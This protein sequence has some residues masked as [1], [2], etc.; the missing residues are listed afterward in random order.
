MFP[1]LH[2]NYKE[3]FH[4]AKGRLS[5]ALA[6]IP[7]EYWYLKPVQNPKIELLGEDKFRSAHIRDALAQGASGKDMGHVTEQADTQIATAFRWQDSKIIVKKAPSYLMKQVIDSGMSTSDFYLQILGHEWGH[8][9]PPYLRDQDKTV[10]SRAMCLSEE[11]FDITLEQFGFDPNKYVYDIYGRVVEI[12]EPNTRKFVESIGQTRDKRIE[13]IVPD[14]YSNYILYLDWCRRNGRNPF[15]D[16]EPNRLLAEYQNSSDFVSTINSNEIINLAVVDAALSFGGFEN[17]L[18]LFVSTQYID[19]GGIE[20]SDLTA[21]LQEPN[22]PQRRALE[23]ITRADQAKALLEE[24]APSFLYMLAHFTDFQ[25]LAELVER[26]MLDQSLTQV[27][28][29][30]EALVGASKKGRHEQAIGDTSYEPMALGVM[31]EAYNEAFERPH[32][33]VGKDIPK[34]LR[35]IGKFRVEHI[36]K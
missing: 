34:L 26:N 31:R 30:K 18:R 28:R 5:E 20:T 1:E 27:H 32:E 14:I 3:V 22:S 16:D 8:L 6:M 2:I 9:L 25:G 17:L 10:A 29:T 11:D 23:G 4:E 24:F 12:R 33:I 19:G 21:Q 13:E 36:R 7:D 15:N 35:D